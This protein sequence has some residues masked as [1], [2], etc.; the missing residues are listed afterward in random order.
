MKNRILCFNNF[1]M[2]DIVIPLG[3]GSIFKN[4]ELK[5]ALRSAD[6]YLTGVRNVH[7]IGDFPGPD[8]KGL[9]YT[10]FREHNMFEY[11]TRNIFYKLKLACEN[12][13]ISDPFLYMN[14]DHFLLMPLEAPTFPYHHKSNGWVGKGKYKVTM[15]QTIDL[16]KKRINNWDTHC[17]ML[18]DKNDFLN[19]VA[20]LDWKKPFGY[21]IKTAYCESVYVVGHYYPDLKIDKPHNE[22]QI[23]EFI[24]GRMYFSV[25]D[26]G[27][28][29]DMITLLTKL[30]PEKSKYEV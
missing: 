21:C 27:V 10:P 1:T 22:K 26:R 25:G 8:F 16:F 14:D 13:N 7:V 29:V 20:K 12:P 4:L 30:Y 2:I 9:V 5:F 15:Q 24:K 3:S 28:N 23:E 11:L 18:I 17:P 6:K 19:T